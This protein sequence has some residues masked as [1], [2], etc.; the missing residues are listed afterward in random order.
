[1]RILFLSSWALAPISNGSTLRLHYLLSELA[2]HHA[3]SLAACVFGP[4][5]KAPAEAA[6]LSLERYWPI[7]LDPHDVSAMGRPALHLGLA[8][9][10]ARLRPE[11]TEVVRRALAAG[12]Y[13]LLVASA[14][15]MAGY[16]LLAPAN[17]PRVLEEHNSMARISLERRQAARRPAQRLRTWLSWRKQVAYDRRLLPQFDRI[18]MVSEQDRSLTQKILAPFQVPV[19]VI[20]NGVDCAYNA[21]T[22][23]PRRPGSLVFNGSLTYAA[24]YAAMRFFVELVMPL[25]G[26]GHP[27][28]CLT[29]TG[30][31]AGVDLSPF[32]SRRNISLAGHVAD[33]RPHVAEASACVVPITEGGGSRLKVLEALALGTPVVSTAKGVE[34][35]ALRDGEHYLRAETPAEFAAAVGRLWSDPALARRLS[36]CGREVV[37]RECDWRFIAP[38]FRQLCED[39]ADAR[40]A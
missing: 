12:L 14:A 15:P 21:F 11:A 39:V 23:G 9:G 5:A 7:R 10:Y 24:N 20:P 35:H 13:D 38:K 28:A 26:R 34:G 29:I 18:T 1:M 16:V 31:H 4:A 33:V 36:L 3:V 37:E 8:P 40:R 17:L 2:S 22:L 6:S 19:D 27:D 30:D 25:I 32:S